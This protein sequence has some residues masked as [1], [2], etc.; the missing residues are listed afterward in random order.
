MPRAYEHYAAAGYEIAA[1]AETKTGVEFAFID[2]TRALGCM[3]E[4][5]ERSKV[6]GFYSFVHDAAKHW[7]GSEPVRGTDIGGQQP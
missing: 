5:Y 7:D 2:T 1:R 6:A 3:V 4:V